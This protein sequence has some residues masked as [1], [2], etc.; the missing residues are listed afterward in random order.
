MLGWLETKAYQMAT[1]SECVQ[2]SAYPINHKNVG[3]RVVA[4][5][6][7]PKNNRI[8]LHQIIIVKF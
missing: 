8:I 4:Q 5:P 1:K 7:M 2:T 3:R 6:N